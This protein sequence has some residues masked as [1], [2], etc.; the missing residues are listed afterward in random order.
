LERPGASAWHR[1]GD[2]L[3][4][5]SCWNWATTA[6]ETGQRRLELGAD[7]SKRRHRRLELEGGGVSRGCS[8]GSGGTN[9]GAATR[10]GE[11]AVRAE[12][13]LVG[14]TAG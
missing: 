3:R 11:V 13:W 5:G 6:S 4:D 7:G 8:R 14:V 1:R 2:A 9:R 10:A 12:G